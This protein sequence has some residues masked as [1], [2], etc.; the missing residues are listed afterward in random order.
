MLRNMS[1]EYIKLPAQAEYLVNVFF[2]H[3]RRVLHHVC[4]SKQF[5]LALE[6]AFLIC[7]SLSQG[8]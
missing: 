1:F 8:V 5:N 6:S 4:S 2:S 3:T 7:R